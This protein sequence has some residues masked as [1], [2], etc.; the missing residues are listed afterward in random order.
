MDG[1]VST[2]AAYSGF[3]SSL[4]M[5][6]VIIPRVPSAAQKRRVRSYPREVLGVIVPVSIMVPSTRTTLRP[7]I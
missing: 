3:G 6:S 1:S 4:Q 7:L 5:I 2:L